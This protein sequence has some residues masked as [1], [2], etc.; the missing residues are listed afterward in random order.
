MTQIQSSDTTNSRDDAPQEAHDFAVQIGWFPVYFL[1]T[2]PEEACTFAVDAL[3]RCVPPP[4]AMT[5]DVYYENRVERVATIDVAVSALVDGAQ[6][7]FVGGLLNGAMLGSACASI[8]SP[9]QHN[10]RT[11]LPPDIAAMGYKSI[12]AEWPE[13]RIGP[14]SLASFFRW[15]NSRRR[16]E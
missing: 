2:S 10:E 5:F 11:V 12:D 9:A 6:R 8:S 13:Q 3:K 14:D 16:S 4:D 15:L 1:S 7:V